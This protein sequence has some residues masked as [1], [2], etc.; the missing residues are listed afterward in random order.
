MA[1]PKGIEPS[2]SRQMPVAQPL[3]Y[4]L[5]PMR[6]RNTTVCK[7]ARQPGLGEPRHEAL[8]QE[9]EVAGQLW[10]NPAQKATQISRFRQI[11]RAIR[12][13]TA[14]IHFETTVAADSDYASFIACRHTGSEVNFSPAHEPFPAPPRQTLQMMQARDDEIIRRIAA[15]DQS[16]IEALYASHQ[17]RVY[18][19]ILRRVRS[20]AVAEELVNEVFMEIWRNAAKFEGRSSLSSWMLA[21]AHNRAISA[22]RRRREEAM[23]EETAAA[24]PD[25][26]DTP[27]VEAQKGDKG[28]LIRQC[29]GQLS[30][31]HG[32]VIDLV[33]YH[34]MSVGEVAEVLGV[35]AN[36]VKTRLF[37][38]RKKLSELLSHAGVDRGWP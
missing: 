11:V 34:E 20:E 23:D 25:E 27:E 18:R 6:A 10:Q 17:V 32:A 7:A 8:D 38:A 36:T 35:P 21:I 26:G 37:H 3:S 1:K 29:I 31:D 19:F 24:I 30:D 15:K 22:M 4:G 2:S 12:L 28:A 14:I 16:A 9:A 5:Y 33:Y 13:F